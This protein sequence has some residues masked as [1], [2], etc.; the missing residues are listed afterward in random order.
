[1]TKHLLLAAGSL[2]LLAGAGTLQGCFDD[3]GGGYGYGR[4]GYYSRPY[5]SEPYYGGGYEE[6][7]HWWQNHEA[8][9]ARHEAHEEREERREAREHHD[10]DD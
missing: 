9:E 5:Y 1:M 10:H 2:M 3:D 7:P 8:A 6:H 4:G